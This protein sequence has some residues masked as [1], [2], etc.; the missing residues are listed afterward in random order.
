MENSKIVC[1]C[2]KNSNV[3]QEDSLRLFASY[4]RWTRAK[5]I[6]MLEEYGAGYIYTPSG[7]VIP[8]SE[9]ARRNLLQRLPVIIV[10]GKSKTVTKLTYL[11]NRRIKAARKRTNK[12]VEREIALEARKAAREEREA[13]RETM[14]MFVSGTTYATKKH[15]GQ[16]KSLGSIG[17]YNSVEC[18]RLQIWENR[19]LFAGE[20]ARKHVEF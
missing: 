1:K 9:K 19:T 3:L 16:A 8:D 18:K 10:V 4:T 2:A 12:R 5:A 11:D 7:I 15:Q 17:R 6:A 13:H 14:R 20:R